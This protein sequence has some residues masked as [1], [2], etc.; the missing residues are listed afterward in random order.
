MTHIT[1]YE[2]ADDGS[3]TVWGS[4]VTDAEYLAAAAKK[5]SR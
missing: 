5:N 3:E 2:A 4:Q 1:V